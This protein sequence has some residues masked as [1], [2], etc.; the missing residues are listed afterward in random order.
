MDAEGLDRILSV[1]L[2]LLQNDVAQADELF[3]LLDK[4]LYESPV[5]HLPVDIHDAVDRQLRL[6]HAVSS[7]AERMRRLFEITQVLLRVSEA[8]RSVVYCGD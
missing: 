4:V 1:N 2:G 8:S 3:H 7:D 6:D 5:Y